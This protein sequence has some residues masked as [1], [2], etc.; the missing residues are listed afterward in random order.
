[1]NIEIEQLEF[2]RGCSIFYSY[3]A[4][5]MKRGTSEAVPS[6]RFS[7]LHFSLLHINIKVNMKSL[8]FFNKFFKSYPQNWG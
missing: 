3:M 2:T 7:I 8:L 5:A 6:L 1:M 4:N